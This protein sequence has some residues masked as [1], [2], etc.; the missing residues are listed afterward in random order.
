MTISRNPSV[1]L[2]R[3]SESES[4]KLPVPR[5]LNKKEKE[6]MESKRERVG[7]RVGEKVS[8]REKKRGDRESEWAPLPGSGR[9]AAT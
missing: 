7:E 2:G 5:H 6:R 8:K 4:E 1:K 9:W 3:V